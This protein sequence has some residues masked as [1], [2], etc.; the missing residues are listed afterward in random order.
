M[1]D[2]VRVSLS[3]EK[4]LFD[5]LEKLVR[6]SGYTNRS[7]FVRDLVRDRLVQEQWKGAGNALATLTII[8][9][10]PSRELGSRLTGIQHHHAGRV[11]AAT[12][13]HLDERLCAEMIMMRGPADELT[14]LSDDIRHQ[15][16]HGP[17]GFNHTGS[18]LH[19]R[20]LLNTTAF[21]PNKPVEIPPVLADQRLRVVEKPL[22]DFRVCRVQQIVHVSF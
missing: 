12:H 4:P 7:E 8:Y 6:Q 10:H 21:V 19:R 9:D 5:R 15:S 14:H 13:G 17:V 22:P 3:I 18:Q 1:P 2:L 11:L 20:S 16:H